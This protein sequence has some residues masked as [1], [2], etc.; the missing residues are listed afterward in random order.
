MTRTLERAGLAAGILAIVFGAAFGQSDAG[1]KFE[2]ADIHPSP[3]STG[4]GNQ[5]MRGGFYRGGRYEVRTATMVDLIRTAYAVEPDKVTGGPGWME[6][7]QFDIIA[8]APPDA[9]A[10]MLRMM[11]QNVLADR[12]KLVVH[13]DTKP[14]PAYVLTPGKKVQL[15]PSDGSGETGC[16]LQPQPDPPPPTPGEGG[17][18][19][20][21]VM[22]GINGNV[23]RFGAGSYIVYSC[24]NVTIADF[25]DQVR[26]WF[27]NGLRNNRVFDQTELKG[28][29]NFDL[30]YS[31]KLPV[32][33][34]AGTGSDSVTLAEAI[35][36]Q[37][38]LKL[39]LTKVPMPV[40]AVDS[41]NEKPTDNLPGITEKMPVAPTEFE[42]A[43]IKP[44]APIEPG[45]G[46]GRGGCFFCPGCC[47]NL[48]HESMADMIGLAWNLN[49]NYSNRIIGLPKSMDSANWDIIAKASTMAPLNAPP[50]GQAPVAQ[51]DFDSLRVML[52]ALLKDR[53]KL[54]LHEEQRPLPGYALVAVKPKLKKADPSNRSACNEGP[55]PD[56]KDPRT[57]NPAAG[58]LFTCLNMTMAEFA[59]QIPMRA[60]GYFGQ[61]PGGV[62]DATKLEGAYDITLN[63][64]GAGVIGGGGGRGGGG[65]NSIPAGAGAAEASDPGGAISLQEAIEKQLG[66]KLEPQKNMGK[67]LVVDHVEEKPTDN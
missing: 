30:K 57:T 45:Q 47:V 26:N 52:Q 48:S 5:F 58:R 60:G 41:V 54:V 23:F 34:A 3:S 65:E 33:V 18:G 61:F 27:F 7:D 17:G 19:R 8:K 24:H 53:F 15:K 1:P 2:A 9:T 44:S 4:N 22:I 38:G 56:G 46:F 64:S 63:F 40:I 43:D 39:E 6:K 21:M 66:L 29:W 31:P 55:G 62:V 12:F 14:L 59:D 25:A 37:L 42:V 50:N 11:L 16:K 28:S 35:D 13:N 51:V 67:V 20:G 49:G 32:L 10:E 36:K